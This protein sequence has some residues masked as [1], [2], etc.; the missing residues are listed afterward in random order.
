MKKFYCVLTAIV[1]MMM[2]VGCPDAA[3]GGNEEKNNDA[4]GN[5][6]VP[7]YTII[8]SANGG[9]GTM[10]KMVC[11][12][13]KVY[14][15][16]KCEFSREGYI[17]AGWD[18]LLYRGHWNGRDHLGSKQIIYN[19][20]ETD[21]DIIILTA[22]WMKK[23][24]VDESGDFVMGEKVFSKTGMVTVLSKTTAFLC[25]Q[26]E[27]AFLLDRNRVVLGKYS[28]GKYE[29]TW[30]LYQ[31][32]M[33]V[34][35]DEDFSPMRP[36]AFEDW[37][38]AII[39]CNR[40]S[41]LTGKTPCYTVEGVSDWCMVSAP[42]GDDYSLK[43]DEY[44]LRECDED[45]YKEACRNWYNIQ[46]DW[47]ANG[48]RLP[49]E[50]EWECAARGGVYSDNTADPWNYTYSGSNNYED[51][52]SSSFDSIVGSKSPNTLGLYDMSGN[53]YEF[54]WDIL[55]Q[56]NASTPITGPDIQSINEDD[57]IPQNL[58]EHYHVARNYSPNDSRF[59]SYGGFRLAC[60][61]E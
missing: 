30:E 5:V 26:E 50:L 4:A 43:Y 60:T 32:I 55:E 41:L 27:G 2:F 37:N 13:G 15:V 58:Y 61:V 24:R 28:I 51:V 1:V 20:S 9:H 18:G 3:N 48:Y 35:F 14:D 17:F 10:S 42:V 19:L 38:N 57:F 36:A 47:N 40:L 33:G 52:A 53:A 7:S 22:Q 8:F 56:I 46:C 6:S 25:D 23:M 11:E 31:A 29:V 21:G 59:G 16:P 34:N 54:C 39:F 45:R 44:G 12:I 49:T